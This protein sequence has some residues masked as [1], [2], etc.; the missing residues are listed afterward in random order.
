MTAQEAAQ[1]LRDITRYFA[2]HE[3]VS[4]S[5]LAQ[6]DKLRSIASAIEAG[7]FDKPAG[8]VGALTHDDIR[9]L[10]RAAKLPKMMYDTEGFRELLMRFVALAATA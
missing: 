7:E 2:P 9:R 4:A 6:A 1:F 8:T 3:R 10:A 5:A